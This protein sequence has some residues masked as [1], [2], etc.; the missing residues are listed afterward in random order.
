MDAK[1][2]DNII[3]I[4]DS[5]GNQK[6]F[7]VLITLDSDEEKKS[8]IIFSDMEKDENGKIEIHANIYDSGK[9]EF[10]LFPIETDKEWKMIDNII[11]SVSEAVKEEM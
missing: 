6:E 2:T 3:I 10:K 8:Y 9:S 5:E 1:L 4:T 7:N 11:K